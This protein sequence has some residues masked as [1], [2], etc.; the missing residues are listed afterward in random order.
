MCVVSQYRPHSEQ[1]AI[2]V[3]RPNLFG[4][5]KEGV[6]KVLSQERLCP[7]LLCKKGSENLPMQCCE[8]ALIHDVVR[9]GPDPAVVTL[10]IGVHVH[11]NL[12]SS[13]VHG[14]V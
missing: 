7:P 12:F 6:E 5:P 4:P 14:P 10:I 3:V 13:A 2:L 1:L 11:S 9:G 8:N